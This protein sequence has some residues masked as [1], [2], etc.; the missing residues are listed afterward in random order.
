MPFVVKLSPVVGEDTVAQHT[1]L[2]VMFPSPSSVMFPP[3]T[4]VAEPIEVTAVVVRVAIIIG[5]VV[6]ESS[7]P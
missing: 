3:E 5:L 1:P 2:A 4:A 6:N 7:L